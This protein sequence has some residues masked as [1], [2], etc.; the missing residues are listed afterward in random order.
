VIVLEFMFAALCIVYL[1]L[2][3][4]LVNIGRVCIVTFCQYQSKKLCKPKVF[5][6]LRQQGHQ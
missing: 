1:F 6:V 5:A 2:L 3:P 4:L